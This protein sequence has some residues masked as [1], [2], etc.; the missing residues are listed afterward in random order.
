MLRVLTIPLVAL[1]SAP[2]AAPAPTG[3]PLLIFISFSMPEASLR[4]LAREAERTGA[5]LV[6]RG[7]VEDSWEATLKRIA[8]I[9]S[10][11]GRLGQDV[12]GPSIAVDPTL[13]RRFEVTE[14]PAF[15]LTGDALERCDRHRCPVP[16][17]VRLG[18]DVSLD[19]AL[20]RFAR[21]RGW[22]SPAARALLR[23]LRAPQGRG[24]D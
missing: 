5:V 2:V 17:H 13:F 14:V 9:L 22:Q 23:R 10:A 20:A 24:D 4:G 18:G 1:L 19:Y 8:G 15:I 11:D 7:L 16:D 21:V 12:R 6:L 3:P